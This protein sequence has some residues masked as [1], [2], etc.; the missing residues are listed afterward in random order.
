MQLEREAEQAIVRRLREE[1]A[2]RVS[3]FGSRARGDAEPDSDVDV[4]VEWG[5]PKTLLD[6]ARIERELREEIGHDVDLRTAEDL[7]PY[8]RDRVERERE[9]L[10]A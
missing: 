9:E 6:V 1:G 7:S 2:T 10:R 3:L 5:E 4:L 8:L